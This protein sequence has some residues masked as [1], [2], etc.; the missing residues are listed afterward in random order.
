M[1]SLRLNFVSQP[2]IKSRLRPIK[3]TLLY[4]K[5]FPNWRAPKPGKKTCQIVEEI[6]LSSDSKS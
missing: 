4:W 6:R 3:Y 5:V 1:I 2:Q